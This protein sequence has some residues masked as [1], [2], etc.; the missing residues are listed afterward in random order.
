MEITYD[1]DADALYIRFIKGKFFKNKKIDDL[2]I[3]DLDENGQ[4]LG[5]E[6]LDA[7]KRM[8][9]DSSSEIKVKSLI[10]K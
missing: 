9:L 2:T 6:L 1:K 10:S 3:I 7:S 5:I 8:S 4:I